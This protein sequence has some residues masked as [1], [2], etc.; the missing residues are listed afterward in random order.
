MCNF[1]A[2]KVEQLIGALKAWSATEPRVKGVALVGSWANGRAHAESDVDVVCLVSEPERF[3]ADSSWMG[4]ID[5]KVA[6]LTAGHWSDCDYGRA[7]SR[8]LTFDGGAEVEMS[9][10]APDWASPDPVDPGT[11]RVACDGMR[12]VHDPA[13]LLGKLI[14]VL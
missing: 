12:V 14:A 2:E 8:H 9:F 11:R 5:W 6:G 13:G 1:D 10:V 7:C 4:A 3:R